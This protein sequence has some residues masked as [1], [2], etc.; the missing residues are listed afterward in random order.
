MHVAQPFAEPRQAIKG[1]LTSRIR[2]PAF[3]LQAFGQ[4]HRFSQTVNDRQLTVA[5]LA[6]D[7]VKTIGAQVYSGEDFGG[8]SIV[9]PGT[10]GIWRSG[11]YRSRAYAVLV[12]VRLNG[13]R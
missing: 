13:E 4:T 10:C 9:R 6:N 2:Q 3:I 1:P 11:F 12:P 7:H 8:L 5:K